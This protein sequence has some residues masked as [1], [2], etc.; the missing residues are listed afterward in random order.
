MHTYTVIGAGKM[1]TCI[2]ADLASCPATERVYIA[3]ADLPAAERA[4]QTAGPKAA[5]KQVS[6]ENAVQLL[7]LLGES[8]VAVSAVPYSYNVALTQYAIACGTHLCDLGG[9]PSVV[10][11]QQLQEDA[12]RRAGVAI[13]PDCGL[14]PGLA[15]IVAAQ[16]IASL[17]KV[18]ALKIYVGGL[19]QKPQGPL[20]YK[21]L[22]S[23]HGLINEYKEPADVLRDYKRVS[24]PS[25]REIERVPFPE[26]GIVLEAFSTA[27]GTS[28]LCDTFEGEIRSLEYKTLRYPGHCEKMRAMFDLGL[29]DHEEVAPGISR[30][31][32]N[33]AALERALT[34]P[35]KD[36]VYLRIEASG[37]KDGTYCAIRYSLADKDDGKWTAMQRTTGFSASAVAQLLAEG[38]ITHRGILR[39]ESHVPPMAALSKIAAHGIA[40]TAGPAGFSYVPEM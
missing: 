13:V 33:E 8:D 36:I 21:L 37:E 29:F 39:H 11:L 7:P 3:D 28:T 1:G 23:V 2:A 40:L 27:G 15:T 22:F 31:D 17:D 32:V 24:V 12:A 10:R 16:A 25:L 38:A 5:A 20:Q 35:G 4:A 14:A 9:N 34:L 30:R 26:Y 18:D 19:P 6:L